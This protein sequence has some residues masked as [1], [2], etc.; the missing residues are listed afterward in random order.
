[1]VMET[2]QIA[3]Y[4]ILKTLGLNASGGRAT[5]LAKVGNRQVVLKQFEFAKGAEWGKLKE[6]EREIGILKALQHPKIP[7]YIESFES[8]TG[9]CLVQEYIAAPSLAEVRSR[10]LEQIQDIGRQLLNILVYLQALHPPVLH[11]DLKPE[12]ILCNEEGQ[13]YLIDF[14]LSRLES[15]NVA[16]SSIV[17]G[18]LGF[19]PPE[20]F[21][22]REPSKAA[23]L[24]S[25][26]ATLLC[27]ISGKP[28]TRMSE[29]LEEDYSFSERVYEGL[30]Q[31]YS[32]WLRKMVAPRL[33]DRFPNAAAALEGFEQGQQEAV[34]KLELMGAQHRVELVERF[35]GP[36][37][38][39]SDPR[40][41]QELESATKRYDELNKDDEEDRF[42][43]P[44]KKQLALLSL[45]IRRA[46]LKY[47][48]NPND[49]KAK[50][51]FHAAIEARRRFMR[52][53]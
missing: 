46:N 21:S 24:Y 44:Y 15:D 5:Y 13:V 40:R 14:G 27:L 41:K 3:E 28:P 12:N 49:I 16:I 47:S 23:D 31:S 52:G 30:E 43:S 33:N 39:L 7:R 45:D 10:S 1:M 11:R 9:F 22:G 17:V 48:Q 29:L 32:A 50:N 20:L 34:G 6:L 53:E 25:L 42:A 35:V 26:G 19:M 18:T 2:Q 4:Q 8:K 37:L 51:A 36:V 38:W